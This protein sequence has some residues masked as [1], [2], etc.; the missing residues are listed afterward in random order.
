MPD[1][2]LRRSSSRRDSRRAARRAWRAR[3]AATVRTADGLV[4]AQRGH[5]VREETGELDQ[6]KEGPGAGGRVGVEQSCLLPKLVPLGRWL[7]VAWW[8]LADRRCSQG[9]KRGSMIPGLGEVVGACVVRC[10]Q[11]R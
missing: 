3:A 9:D 2:R 8:W 4:L 5:W 1:R 7:G 6:P 10:V 11:G